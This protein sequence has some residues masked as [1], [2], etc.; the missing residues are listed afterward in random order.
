MDC[1]DVSLSNSAI[2]ANSAGKGAALVVQ[3]ADPTRCSAFA[4]PTAFSDPSGDGSSRSAGLAAG[5]GRISKYGCAKCPSPAVNYTLMGLACT[6]AIAITGILVAFNA[7]SIKRGSSRKPSRLTSIAKVF[8]SYAQKGS[9]VGVSEVAL[10]TKTSVARGESH[11][12]VET[13][14][15]SAAFDREE[16]AD[17][18]ALSAVASSAFLATRRA[19]FG[20]AAAG[21]RRGAP[22]IVEEEFEEEEDPEDADED[23]VAVDERRRPGGRGARARRDE[24]GDGDGDEDVCSQADTGATISDLPHAHHLRDLFILTCIVALFL[25]HPIISRQIFLLYA[26]TRMQCWSGEHALWSATLGAAAT[27]LWVFGIPLVAFLLL[28]RNRHS[29]SDRRVLLRYGF[30]LRGYKRSRYYWEEVIILRKLAF[31]FVASFFASRPV[32]Q[33]LLGTGVLVIAL[34]AN[35]ALRPYTI[36]LLLYAGLLLYTGVSETDSA[37]TTWIIILANAA[38]LL[39]W[40]AAILW[41][42]FRTALS[43][44]RRRYSHLPV[45]RLA[46]RL[47]ERI[48]NISAV[49]A[50]LEAADDGE[51]EKPR[52]AADADRETDVDASDPDRDRPPPPAARTA[53][54]DGT[55]AGG[56]APLNS[57]AHAQRLPLAVDPKD[58][59]QQGYDV[60]EHSDEPNS[61]WP[62]RR[63]GRGSI[64]EADRD[65]DQATFKL[66]MHRA[67]SGGARDRDRLPREQNPPH[68]ISLTARA[69]PPLTALPRSISGADRPHSAGA[70]SSCRRTSSPLI[71]VR[72]GPSRSGHSPSALARTD[73]EAGRRDGVGGS[74]WAHRR[75]SLPSDAPWA[76]KGLD[77]D[78]PRPIASTMA[79]F[80]AQRHQHSGS[81][82]APASPLPLGHDPR[83]DPCE[84]SRSSSPDRSV[85]IT[86]PPNAQL[87]A[88][89]DDL[90]P[91]K[92]VEI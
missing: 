41:E 43:H 91:V 70:L 49:R 29:L 2:Q 32:V 4:D 82:R 74:S 7:R 73:Q 59:L 48:Q 22:S 15:Q 61:G 19:R 54:A 47:N 64:P 76:S 85:V 89:R 86:S 75:A 10:S 16:D 44:T 24:A 35:V 42:I 88:T 21:A 55:T 30:L 12:L 5:Y 58:Y 31:I 72:V 20:E 39:F 60:T 53:A 57:D 23:L 6:I 18:D 90:S 28:T 50:W 83:D 81:P 33:G 46:D 26:C 17:A 38:F 51:V 13:F 87:Q 56:G 14:S 67:G 63:G 25:A 68:F 62:S 80:A 52:R 65:V 40:L 1:G 8:M 69:D 37:A 66:A 45:M 27:A 77:I 34:V 36:H 84:I 3:D 79:A 78:L 11:G 92:V 71:G 9:V